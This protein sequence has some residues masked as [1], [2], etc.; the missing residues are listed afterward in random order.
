MALVL[1][2]PYAVKQSSRLGLQNTPTASLQ[3]GKTPQT[4][5]LD[6]TLKT[7]IEKFL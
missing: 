7:L 4:S 3:K 2:N 5:I 1:N 6:M